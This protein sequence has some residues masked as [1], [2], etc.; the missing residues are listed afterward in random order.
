MKKET[1]WMEKGMDTFILKKEIIKIQLFTITEVKMMNTHKIEVLFM[2]NILL[3][4]NNVKNKCLKKVTKKTF[5]KI[6]VFI[7]WHQ[8]IN[9]EQILE[10]RLE[11]NSRLN[12]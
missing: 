12:H 6:L 1:T 11:R 8:E 2:K 4:I 5:L 10:S 9:I 7:I 3:I